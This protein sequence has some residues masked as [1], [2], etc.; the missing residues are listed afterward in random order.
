VV[1]TFRTRYYIEIEVLDLI[2]A[3]RISGPAIVRGCDTPVGQE[4]TLRIPVGKVVLY[5]QDD[6]WRDSLAKGID[7]LDHHYPFAVARLGQ[8]CLAIAI[9]GRNHYTY[10][11]NSYYK[12][13]L[14]EVIDIVIHDAVLGL[15]VSYESKPLA[16]NL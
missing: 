5:S 3:Y 2:Q 12:S 8:L 15:D 1:F 16:N 9:R 11:D 13:S 4:V 6:K 7:S 14:V 10:K